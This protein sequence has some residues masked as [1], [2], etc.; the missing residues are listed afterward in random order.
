MAA[1]LSTHEL[2]AAHQSGD[3]EG[4]KVWLR[5][6]HLLACGIASLINVADPE[7]VIIG[8]GIARAGDALFAPLRQKLDRMEWRPHGKQV[9]LVAAT[10]GEYAG[11]LGA[12][13]NAMGY[14]R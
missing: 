11:A 13:R 12:A 8:G 3:A 9:R 6:V 14:S 10:L 7:V 1:G 5:S 4:T 2:I